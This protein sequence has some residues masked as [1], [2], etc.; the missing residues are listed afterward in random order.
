MNKE[1]KRKM[2][3]HPSFTNIRSFTSYKFSML[4]TRALWDLFWAKLTGRN[5]NLAVFPKQEQRYN[6]NRRLLG[7]KDIP[8][9]QI[10]GTFNRECD[11]DYQFRPLSKHLSHRWVNTFINLEHDGWP[12][13]LVHKVG[14]H[15]YVEHGHHRV[16]V[17]RSTGMVFIEAK[18]WDYPIQPQQTETCPSI[19]C[20][21]RSSSKAY[22][23][24]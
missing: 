13:I 16:S 17:A 22:A 1:R 9:E 12:S 7:T 2:N 5:A 11:F 10:I 23:A 21:E 6:P 8:V 18:V 14:E 19:R 20:A 4:R 3:I 15:Y 24:G